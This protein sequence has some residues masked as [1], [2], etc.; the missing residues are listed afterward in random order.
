MENTVET[1]LNADTLT[2]PTNN[3]TSDTSTSGTQ[4]VSTPFKTFATQADFDRHAVGIKNDA[5]REA[6]KEIMS[7]LGLKSNEKEK[8]TKFKEAYEAS[9]SET[10][11]Q[12]KT[13]SELTASVE[14]LN[15]QLNDKNALISALTLSSGKTI[16]DVSKY[17]KMAKGL[18][19]ENTDMTTALKEVM[20]MF[21]HEV[22]SVPTGTPLQE[23]L[24][25]KAPSK[26]D[27]PFISGNLTLQGQLIKADKD[28][29]RKLYFQAKGR[30]PN[31]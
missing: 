8:L 5:R 18:V 13:L 16:D 28:M 11:R 7:A 30:Y 31:W 14:A 25:Q 26:E 29:A 22:K 6:E 15:N 4:D 21:K 20:E 9:L 27:N 3:G 17:V 23:P 24:S 10:E 12:A 19:D 2:A 1:G